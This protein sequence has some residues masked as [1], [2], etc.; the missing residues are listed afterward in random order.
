[1][2]SKS[3]VILLKVFVFAALDSGLKSQKNPKAYGSI[4][5]KYPPFHYSTSNEHKFFSI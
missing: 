2:T 5:G 1:M 3:E 4:V